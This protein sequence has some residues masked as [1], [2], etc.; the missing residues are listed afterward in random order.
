VL[1]PLPCTL[2]SFDEIFPT[3]ESC[4][5][6]WESQ[7]WKYEYACPRC[8]S[9]YGYEMK[10][11]GVIQ[12]ARR[13]CRYQTSSTARTMLHKTKLPFRSWFR[14]ML[15]YA[16]RPLTTVREM[17]KELGV[18]GKTAWLMMRKIREAFGYCRDEYGTTY[19]EE[20]RDNGAEQAERAGR[21]ERAE[22]AER[23]EQVE[24][25]ERA[26]RAEQ[27]GR[28]ERAEQ[29]GRPEPLTTFATFTSLTSLTDFA[30][31]TDFASFMKLPK[32]TG[33]KGWRE[34]VSGR[35]LA[36]VRCCVCSPTLRRIE[37][38]LAE[39]FRLGFR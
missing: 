32:L 10:G 39:R 25:A 18:A 23:V 29:V 31:F 27:V 16:E 36:Y 30:D 15:I 6:Y 21:A 26:G 22:R 4:R 38:E 5:T 9:F 17:A 14:A 24:Q 7:L 11:R 20:D 8:G 3:E 28:F 1:L 12:C 35:F 19:A 2:E 37:G 33:L 13:R 34:K